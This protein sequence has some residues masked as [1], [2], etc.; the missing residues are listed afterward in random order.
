MTTEQVLGMDSGVVSTV[1][2]PQLDRFGIVSTVS[3]PQLDRFG[4]AT[5]RVENGSFVLVMMG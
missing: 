3:S 2:S 1:A 5:E 4:V